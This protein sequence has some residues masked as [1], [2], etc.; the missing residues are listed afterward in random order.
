MLHQE[1]TGKIL[2][3]FYSVYNDLGYGFLE[4]VYENALI[5]ELRKM[6]L[7]VVRQRPIKVYYDNVLVGEYFADI[8]VENAVIVELKA[9]EVLH[10]SH[11]NQLTNYLKATEIEVGLLLNFGEEPEFARKILTNDRKK[12]RV[13]P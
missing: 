13:N 9:V 1:I 10:E 11:A 2:K 7:K 12:I 6:D 4:K 8:I 3:A 5:H